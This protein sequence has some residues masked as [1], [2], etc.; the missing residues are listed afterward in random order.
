MSTATVEIPTHQLVINL[1]QRAPED[2]DRRQ[3]ARSGVGEN[4]PDL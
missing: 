2:A 4:L 3:M 1:C